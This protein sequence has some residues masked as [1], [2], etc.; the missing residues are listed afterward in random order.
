MS[1][2]LFNLRGRAFT[3]AFTIMELVLALVILGVLAGLAFVAY[4]SQVAGSE[5]SLNESTAMVTADVI[6]AQN[7]SDQSTECFV[8][9]A[10]EP[11]GSQ[12]DIAQLPY[13]DSIPADVSAVYMSACDLTLLFDDGTACYGVSF[14]SDPPG[15]AYSGAWTCDVTSTPYPVSGFNLT[16]E[17]GSLLV[18]W[19]A[20]IPDPAA[21]VIEYLATIDPPHS[22][23]TAPAAFSSCRVEGLSNGTAY[24]VTLLARTRFGTEEVYVSDAPSIPLG[25][26]SAPTSP[27]LSAAPGALEGS[28]GES[29]DDGGAPVTVYTATAD[30]RTAL[31]AEQAKARADLRAEHKVEYTSLVADQKATSGALTA[32]FR[33][34]DADLKSA[35]TVEREA[36]TAQYLSDIQ[37]KTREERLSLRDVYRA[38]R[39]AIDQFYAKARADLRSAYN[40]DL[41]ALRA[42]QAQQRTDLT[43]SHKQDRND[44]SAVFRSQTSALSKN[45]ARNA[46]CT[47]PAPATSCTITG[48][49]PS[50][51]YVLTVK[52]TA[53]GGV[54]PPSASSEPGK[55][56]PAPS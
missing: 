2:L 6:R 56:L 37:G 10:K 9:A 53:E 47:V 54:S 19:S 35:R 42:T 51:S 36:R 34:D 31:L 22:S 45:P 39:T 40:T 7:L 21:P 43:T 18:S 33:L 48:L 25:K 55:P 50:L 32:Q 15:A 14:P 41:S 11:T 24:S 46:S 3:A 16:P 44:Q 52:A 13:A 29:V 1:T 28:W 20:P 12:A 30:A 26:P 27:S 23:C 38:D 8:D 4:N 49:D 5:A 17:D